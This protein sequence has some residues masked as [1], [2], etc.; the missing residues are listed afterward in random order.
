LDSHAIQNWRVTQEQQSAEPRHGS[1]GNL[2]WRQSGL[3]G[4][5][6]GRAYHGEELFQLAKKRVS[7]QRAEQELMCIKI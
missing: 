1:P 4:L 5:F 3:V 7:N 2:G 6:N